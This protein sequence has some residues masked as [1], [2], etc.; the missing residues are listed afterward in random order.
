V[1]VAERNT[2]MRDHYTAILFLRNADNTRFEQLK[3]ELSNGFSKGRDEYPATLIDA[4]QLLL[5]HKGSTSP[6][7]AQPTTPYRGTR[8]DSGRGNSGRGTSPGR[9]GRTG[10]T[11][12]QVA[13]CLA[14]VQNHFPDGIPNHF[15]LLD[16]DST[17]SIFCNADLLTDIHDVDEPLYLETNGGGYQVSTQMGTIK[18]FG[19]VWYNPESIAN[20]LSLAQ[21][22]LV[23]RTD[24]LPAFHVHRLDGCGSTIFAKHES[25]L[26]LYNASTTPVANSIDTKSSIFAYSYLQTV[27]HNKTKFT[28]RQIDAADSARKLYWFLGRPGHSRFL[29]ILKENH[30]LNCPLTVDDAQRAVQIYGKDVAFL[31]G[32]TTASPAKDHIVDFTPVAVCPELLS[33]HPNVTLCCDLFYVLGLGFSL[34]TSR[35]LRYLSCHF[36]ADRSKPTITKCIAADLAIYRNRGFNPTDL[37][38][39]GEY[40]AL[41]AVFPTIHFNICA[42]DDHFPEIERAV[43]TV[44]ESIRATIHGMP[45]ARTRPSCPCERACY[46]RN[47][48]LKHAPASRWCELYLVPSYYCHWCSEN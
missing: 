11:F 35:N 19:P 21:V 37:H 25:G 44:K 20:V 24:Q 2:Y 4:H 5:A 15:F 9:G 45:Y 46:V 16:S 10:R 38:A 27:A 8:P 18:D 36:I 40:D 42:A 48:K 28:A 7:K 12:V 41:Q 14:Q 34:S 3:T 47:P 39:D 22:R 17:V 26:Y 1:T 13:L 30:I 33:L 31:K 29:S 23:R 43:R 6:K 32:K